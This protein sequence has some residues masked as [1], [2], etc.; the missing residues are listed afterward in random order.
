MSETRKLAAFLIFYVVRYSEEQF[1][2]FA[3]VAAA[4][5]PCQP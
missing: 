3:E 2:L 5:T 4:F 1:A